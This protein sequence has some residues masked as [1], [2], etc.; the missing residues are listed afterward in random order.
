MSSRWSVLG[1]GLSADRPRSAVGG[2]ERQRTNDATRAMSRF[3][4][5]SRRDLLHTL[6]V[7]AG[8]V[9]VS[10]IGLAA[11]LFGDG[12]RDIAAWAARRPFGRGDRLASGTIAS[13]ELIARSPIYSSHHWRRR[14]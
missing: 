5:G 13:Q 3:A 8:L 12:L 1:S 2:R 9:A 7:P 14:L 6:R 10:L 11:G 4:A